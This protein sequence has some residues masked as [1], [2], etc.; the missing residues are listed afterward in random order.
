MLNLPPALLPNAFLPYFLLG[1]ATLLEGPFSLLIAGRLFPAACF[2]PA[3]GIFIGYFGNLI[4][5]M[6]LVFAWTIF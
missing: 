1:L 2:L 5:D 6:G 4:A 3:S